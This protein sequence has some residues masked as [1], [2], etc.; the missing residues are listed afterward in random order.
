MAALLG[1]SAAHAGVLF[2]A[3]LSE[4][5]LLSLVHDLTHPRSRELV[6]ALEAVN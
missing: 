3:S 4:W 1:A 2:A 6:E 5:P